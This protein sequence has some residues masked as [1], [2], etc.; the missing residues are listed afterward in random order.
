[1]ASIRP[2]VPFEE[3]GE[4]ATFA[5]EVLL[6]L[7]R[8]QKE[9]PCKFFYDERGAELFEQICELDEYYPT[10]TEL[11]IM[12]RHAPEMAEVLGEG[13]ILIEYGSGASLKTRILL[14]AAPDL[15]AFVPID[16]SGEQL[17]K[18]AADIREAYPRLRVE[19]VCADYTRPFELPLPAGPQAR[20][21]VYFPGS[22]IG[23]F[24][25]ERAVD[26]LRHIGEVCGR[27]GGLLIGVDRL[28]PPGEVVPAY[29]D[30]RGVTAEFN[31]N[32][33]RRINR[34]LGADFRL[35]RFSH[36]A[37]FNPHESRIEMHLVSLENQTVT[38][39]GRAFRFRRGET[40]WTENSYKYSPEQFERLAKDAGM[41]IDCT[42][43]DPDRLFDV[44]Y[45]RIA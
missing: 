22:T 1:M 2:F 12:R 30:A 26:F 24:D 29:A 41:R 44:H 25:P 4:A 40:I 39:R 13:S 36:Y 3:H 19:P 27:E 35:D 43:S 7:S 8:R 21:V 37:F 33:L 17:E 32:L 28:K 5:D 31:L 20:R 42:W 9:L 45:L 14:D 16:I 34:E 10:R 6:G 18:V 23:N 11:A 15:A 38:V